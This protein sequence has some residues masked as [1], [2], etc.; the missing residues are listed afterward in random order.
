M[1]NNTDLRGKLEWFAVTTVVMISC[2]VVANAIPFFDSLTGLIG[3]SFVPIACW[4]LP[5]IFFYLSQK[6]DG[7][8]IA[9]LEWVALI[10]IFLLG[11]VLTGVGTY[12]NMRDI[13][14]DWEKYGAPFSCICTGIWNTCDCSPSHTG[15]DCPP[16]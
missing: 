10:F 6:R 11:I 4:N 9:I 12:S 3:A 16:E 2:I 5:I 1:V 14:N 15:M 13:V 7:K 8:S